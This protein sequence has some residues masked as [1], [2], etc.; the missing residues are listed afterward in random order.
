MR[1]RP[2]F[3]SLIL[4]L[5]W[6]SLN[7]AETVGANSQ[8]PNVYRIAYL[9]RFY[10]FQFVN[11]QK[12]SGFVID[13][14]NQIAKEE[15]MEIEWVPMN[16]Y[17]AMEA[18]KSRRVDAVAGLKYTA[19]RSNVF[20]FSEPF[21]TVSHSLIVPENNES[22]ESMADLGNKVV[23]VERG[24]VALDLLQNVRS[25][26]VI[27]AQDQGNAFRLLQLRRAD[28]FLGNSQYIEFLLKG[29]HLQEQY[30]VVNT[31]ILPSDYALATYKGNEAFLEL[32]NKGLI[33]VRANQQFQTIYN[34]WFGQASAQLSKRLQFIIRIM[35]AVF[36]G[37]LLY[38]YFSLRWNRRLKSEVYRRT[39]ELEQMNRLLEEK[40]EEEQKLRSQLIHKEK[41][42]ALGHLVAG[43]A[44]EI[45]N[46]LTSIKAFVEL[47]PHKFENP[48]FREEVSKF[49]PSEITRLDRIVSDLLDYAKPQTAKKEVFQVSQCF[50]SIFPLFKSSFAQKEIALIDR[51]DPDHQVYAD[52]GLFKQVAVNVLLNSVD[53][54]DRGGQIVC[55]SEAVDGQL[56]I[57]IEDNGKGI[58]EAELGKIFEPFYTSKT[59]GTG[60]GLSLSLDYMR[61]NNGD[62]QVESKPGKGTKVILSLPLKEEVRNE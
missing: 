28:A 30:K 5:V 43:I 47:I 44:H 16:L 57:T 59:H 23:A 31:L 25:V 61:E 55:S 6:I 45:R 1:S 36:I 56:I 17:D 50:D 13:L 12:P 52:Y 18:L 35:S 29:N 20:E 51:I 14:L 9:N 58:S 40:I 15:Q 21:M 11:E 3:L 39:K 41:M 60:L 38:L 8:L 46:P 34:K 62:L 53:A 2:V 54:L 24:D 27:V 48:K 26:R 10:P 37:L 32:I 7:F 33:Q 4:V 49:V 19:E 22:I 42:Q